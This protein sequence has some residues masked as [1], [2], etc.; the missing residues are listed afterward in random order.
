MK[1]KIS[2][3][4]KEMKEM[5]ALHKKNIELAQQIIGHISGELM[6]LDSTFKSKCF[7]ILKQTYEGV[8]DGITQTKGKLDT[9]RKACVMSIQSGSKLE[10]TF[11][12][13]AVLNKQSQIQRNFIS[14]LSSVA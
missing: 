8:A 14:S 9:L 3:F 5:Q 7:K 1:E 4:N 6:V 2:Y 12:E 13:A 11:D 10:T